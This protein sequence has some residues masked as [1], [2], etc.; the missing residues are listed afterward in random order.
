M[1]IK[2]KVLQEFINKKLDILKKKLKPE[3]IIFFGSRASGKASEESDIDI[4]I[5]SEM[6]A[7]I[8]FVKRAAYILKLLHY[9][10]HIDAICYTPSEFERMKN[11]SI[12]LKDALNSGL[13]A[14]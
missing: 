11:M 2:D 8:K 10:R 3:G 7:D 1:L 13:K 4:I 12:I 9:P 14:A 6:F 5:I